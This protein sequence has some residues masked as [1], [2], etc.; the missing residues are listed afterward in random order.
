MKVASVTVTHAV[1]TSPATR[2]RLEQALAQNEKSNDDFILINFNQAAYTGDAEVGHI[3]P[4]AAYDAAHHRVLVMDP[5]RQWY[6]PYWVS[7]Q[8]LLA[9]MATKDSQSKQN[10]G[11]VYIKLNR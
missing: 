1:D 2:A 5:D 8:T 4:I 9:G 10:R 7:T 3:A 6:E 11:W